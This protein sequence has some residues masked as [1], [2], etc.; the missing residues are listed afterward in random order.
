MDREEMEFLELDVDFETDKPVYR[1]PK[2]PQADFKSV[3]GFKFGQKWSQNDDLVHKNRRHVLDDFRKSPEYERLTDKPKAESFTSV[4]DSVEAI[5]VMRAGAPRPLSERL[6][7]IIK[8]YSEDVSVANISRLMNGAPVLKEDV[9]ELATSVMTALVEAGLDANLVDVEIDDK[10]DDVY[11]Y[12]ND[13]ITDDK[14]EQALA[15]LDRQGVAELLK[16]PK[17]DVALGTFQIRVKEKSEDKEGHE[18]VQVQDVSCDKCKSE[19]IMLMREHRARLV[20]KGCQKMTTLSRVEERR[21]YSRLLNEPVLDEGVP[22]KHQLK[23]AK[24]TLLMNDAAANVMGGMNKE[25]ARKFLRDHG[26]TDQ[27]IQEYERSADAPRKKEDLTNPDDF[28]NGEILSYEAKDERKCDQ[29]GGPLPAKTGFFMGKRYCKTCR[30]SPKPFVKSDKKES[31]V[32]EDI[33]LDPNAPPKI[34]ERVKLKDDPQQDDWIISAVSEQLPG[35]PATI[36]VKNVKTGAVKATSQENFGRYEAKPGLLQTS[37]TDHPLNPLHKALAPPAQAATNILRATAVK[38]IESAEL[39]FESRSKVSRVEEWYKTLPAH[40]RPSEKL[41]VQQGDPRVYTVNVSKGYYETACEVV[42]GR[43][44]GTVLS[45]AP[46]EASDELTRLPDGFT[47]LM[48]PNE[49]GERAVEMAESFGYAWGLGKPYFDSMNRP[50][51]VLPVE[52]A[53]HMVQ[54]AGSWSPRTAEAHGPFTLKTEYKIVRDSVPT[55]RPRCKTCGK[56]KP[57]VN[58]KD[59]CKCSDE[60]SKKCEACGAKEQSA[61]DLCQR[62]DRCA[63]G[64][65]NCD[66]KS[67]SEVVTEGY[68]KCTQCDCDKFMDDD[69]DGSGDHTCDCG[70]TESQHKKSESEVVEEAKKRRT[71]ELFPQARKEA[72]V[73]AR[74]RRRALNG[75]TDE[76]PGQCVD[77]ECPDSGTYHDHPDDADEKDEATSTASGAF[78]GRDEADLLIKIHQLGKKTASGD[79]S[80]EDH[81]ELA[82]LL[83]HAKSKGLEK[84]AQ[85]AIAK[86]RAKQTAGKTEANDLLGQEPAQDPMGA[87]DPNAPPALG[88]D[89]SEMPPGVSQDLRNENTIDEIVSEVKSGVYGEWPPALP[90]AVEGQ[91]PDMSQV[92]RPYLS[93]ALLKHGIKPGVRAT[94]DIE[95]KAWQALAYFAKADQPTNDPAVA[96]GAIITPKQRF[97][98]F[99]AEGEPVELTVRPYVVFGLTEERDVIAL[100]HTKQDTAP[101]FLARARD[102]G[103]ALIDLPLDPPAEELDEAGQYRMRG[104]GS[105][106]GYKSPMARDQS[107]LKGA[108]A[109]AQQRARQKGQPSGDAQ[110]VNFSF[111]PSQG[112][113]APQKGSPE[114]MAQGIDKAFGGPPK[115]PVPVRPGGNVGMDPNLATA[116]QTDPG[117]PAPKP[118]GAHVDVAQAANAFSA[119]PRPGLIQR[120]MDWFKQRRAAAA[121]QRKVQDH[122][123][124]VEQRMK[125]DQ[126]VLQLAKDWHL[127]NTTGLGM[128]AQYGPSKMQPDQIQRIMGEIQDMLG[129]MKQAEQKPGVKMRPEFYT[130]KQE[131]EELYSH[132][133]DQAAQAGHGGPKALAMFQYPH[134]SYENKDAAPANVAESNEEGLATR[135]INRKFRMREGTRPKSITADLLRDPD[136]KEV[137]KELREEEAGQN[138]SQGGAPLEG[139]AGSA[140]QA[141]SRL[142]AAGYEMEFSEQGF[143]ALQGMGEQ[144]IPSLKIAPYFGL[145]ANAIDLVLGRKMFGTK[146]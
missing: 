13:Q 78:V 38:H 51:F 140:A 34:G 129:R 35:K 9:D 11:V 64:C 65:C 50:G 21:V 107:V 60:S 14:V 47:F 108:A 70:H 102:L 8:L 114:E 145:D 74:Q 99:T 131:L 10:T 101:A 103:P 73:A 40:R 113:P 29:C 94:I 106:G 88:V 128:Y 138:P 76:G 127:G 52:K 89:H 24:G 54:F 98:A 26:W 18:P 120:G 86:S 25:Q 17:D 85:N 55:S 116:N 130:W 96:E 110:G 49:T 31:D 82:D 123:F 61:A 48:F 69:D 132:F 118:P 139:P 20:C 41:E 79:A 91:E 30:E 126:R 19:A 146:D 83:G 27:R 133:R 1:M 81:E 16:R 43:F 53:E 5:R 46:V 104:K 57:G 117:I 62:C 71:R 122:N 143:A 37:H 119:P 2:S 32:H 36:T 56:L 28:T 141:T 63:D 67:E 15:M 92:L 109:M 45:E 39:Q 97:Q 87:I 66:K 95:H 75:S 23:I 3:N 33:P 22:E 137:L 4:M 59:P 80:P 7:A 58:I 44:Q 115:G 111:D 124:A 72:D 100:A 144:G 6:Q 77:A 134:P 125:R 142:R 136:V 68:G 105:S 135:M 90:N 12:L 42:R 121:D 84:D 112:Q 93:R